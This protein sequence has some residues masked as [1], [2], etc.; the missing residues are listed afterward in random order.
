MCDYVCACALGVAVQRGLG[1]FCLPGEERNAQIKH[2][3]QDAWRKRR[4][5]GGRG[6]SKTIDSE[7]KDGE[8]QEVETQKVAKRRSKRGE[9][10]GGG[11]NAEEK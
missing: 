9:G 2:S 4:D 11:K 5:G 3:E 6:G 10:G 7:E 8:T 1:L